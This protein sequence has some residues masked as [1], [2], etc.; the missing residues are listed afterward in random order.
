MSDSGSKEKCPNCGRTIY[1]NRPSCLYCGWER[2]IDENEKIELKKELVKHS[3]GLDEKDGKKSAPPKQIK[4]RKCGNILKPDAGFCTG[5]GTKTVYSAPASETTVSSNQ[6][7]EKTEFKMKEPTAPSIYTIMMPDFKSR[8][9]ILWIVSAALFFLAAHFPFGIIP[10]EEI[11]TGFRAEW[12]VPFPRELVILSILVVIF[13]SLSLINFMFP[14]K[15]L[16]NRYFRIAFTLSG[17]LYFVFFIRPL[18]VN[19]GTMIFAFVVFIVISCSIKW[20]RDFLDKMEPY[21]AVVFLMNTF[22]FIL[23][24]F[25]KTELLP[26]TKG[27]ITGNAGFLLYLISLLSGIAGCLVKR[28]EQPEVAAPE[29]VLSR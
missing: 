27:A 7:T 22:I 29:S 23:I 13:M 11:R 3:L 9:T 20:L 8:G 1:S 10:P 5:C 15:D 24:L 21:C 19:T 6:T 17:I 16:K 14:G 4:C 25:L 28:S 26:Q 12:P 2:P 18:F